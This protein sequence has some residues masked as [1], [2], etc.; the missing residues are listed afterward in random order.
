MFLEF[1]G[2]LKKYN[3]LDAQNKYSWND[4]TSY[5]VK[6][7]GDHLYH[8]FKLILTGASNENPAFEE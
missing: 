3:A 4:N 7:K 2:I 6:F 1:A 8:I 5:G